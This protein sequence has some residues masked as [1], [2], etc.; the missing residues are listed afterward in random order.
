M[1]EFKYTEEEIKDLINWFKGKKLPKSIRI[2]Q[3]IFI[4]DVERCIALMSEIVI[5]K[6]NKT[7]ESTADMLFKIKDL[8]EKFN[9]GEEIQQS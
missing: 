9:N 5:N 1:D 4:P 8:V 3:A 2:D 6:Q 7:F